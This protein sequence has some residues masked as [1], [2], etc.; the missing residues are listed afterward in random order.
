MKK[1]MWLIILGII[2]VILLAIIITNLNREDDASNEIP[3]GEEI[4]ANFYTINVAKLEE[5][6]DSS[7]SSLIYIG[8]PTCPFCVEMEPIIK[9]VATNESINTFYLNL[10]EMGEA[11]QEKFMQINDFLASG[12]WGTP[13][14]FV[15]SN[16]TI[17]EPKQMGL[18]DEA[19]YRDFLQRIGKL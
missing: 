16:G 6:F 14:L 2:G 5:L 1:Q 8:T 9:D 17:M 3:V 7:E 15:V 12:S 11:D 18:V 10:D 4:V 13:L 19:G